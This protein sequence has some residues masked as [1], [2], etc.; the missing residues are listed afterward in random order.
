MPSIVLVLGTSVVAGLLLGTLFFVG[1]R[2]TVERLGRSEH[3]GRLL[4]TSAL[5]R[6]AVVAV[7]MLALARWHPAAAPT[8]LLGFVLARL[9]VVGRGTRNPQPARAPVSRRRPGGPPWT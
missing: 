3:A 2:W 1:L 6:F 7:A 5:L 8:A 4:L 9:V